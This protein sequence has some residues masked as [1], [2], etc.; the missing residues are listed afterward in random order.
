M[1]I[2][3]EKIK[4]RKEMLKLVK[5]LLAFVPSISF[6]YPWPVSPF[7][8]QHEISAALGEY[9]ISTNGSLHFHKGADIAESAGTTVY[10]SVDGT[11]TSINPTLESGII[12]IT[13]D[14]GTLFGYIH[15]TPDPN[16]LQNEQVVAGQTPLGVIATIPAAH[17]HFQ[18]AGG[19]AN[20]LRQGGLTPYVDN[21]TPAISGVT[22]FYD[23]TSNPVTTNIYG[24]LDIQ[25][26][27]Y[28]PRTGADG[29][30]AGGAIGIYKLMVQFWQNG[31][32]VGS[33]IQ[34]QFDG[35]PSA[36][37]TAVYGPGSTDS[38]FLYWA[39]NDPF[40]QPYNKYWNTKQMA[41]SAY[42]VDAPINAQALYKDGNLQ[43]LIIAS[44]IQGNAVTY[45]IG[46]Q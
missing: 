34:Y 41:G 12:D 22:F 17:L 42:N 39:T 9:R 10:S 29:G 1:E 36:P 4:R 13:D 3:L 25:V 18:E 32:Q 26:N 40:N 11:V 7:N 45:T 33:S 35:I 37:V 27:A 2:L 14:D 38:I 20:P 30:N 19:Q 43:I 28:E 44:D 23:G 16:L 31:A 46:S 6:A 21:N 8:S 24:H 15:V 5:L